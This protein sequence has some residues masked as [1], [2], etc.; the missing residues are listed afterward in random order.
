MRKGLPPTAAA[1]HCPSKARPAGAGH[2]APAMPRGSL[3]DGVQRSRRQS[4]AGR[5]GADGP[6]ATARAPPPTAARIT[7]PVPDT[8]ALLLLI[9]VVVVIVINCRSS[10]GPFL[11]AR[12]DGANPAR[13][14]PP[15]LER[16]SV[17]ASDASPG[18]SARGDRRGATGSPL[19]MDGAGGEGRK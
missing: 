15:A 8:P 12:L 2:V 16:A 13:R 4:K 18:G 11:P 3:L 9:I 10:E 6:L 7:R 5:P 1:P 17:T 14:P 19:L